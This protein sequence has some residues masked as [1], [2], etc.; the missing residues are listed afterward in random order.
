MRPGM[1]RPRR[2]TSRLRSS[3]RRPRARRPRRGARVLSGSGRVDAG[4]TVG[5]AIEPWTEPV[6]KR[7]GAARRSRAT[8]G[9]SV[10]SGARSAGDG[11]AGGATVWPANTMYSRR[12]PPAPQPPPGRA[13][14]ASSLRIVAQPR[15]AAVT[16]RGRCA[17]ASRDSS[18]RQPF[19]PGCGGT[20]LIAGTVRRSPL[21]STVEG[22]GVCGTIRGPRGAIDIE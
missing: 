21:S 22:S 9:P 14:S 8:R 2:R 19:V 11:T 17:P 13:S 15:A 3:T 10:A 16:G 4:G 20:R 12:T 5:S 18:F 6:S 7:G 1:R